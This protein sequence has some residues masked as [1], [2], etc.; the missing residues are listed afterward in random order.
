MIVIFIRFSFTVS[1]P[2][3]Q[4]Y[5]IFHLLKTDYICYIKSS[6]IGSQKGRRQ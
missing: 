6:S 5:H 3:C 2:I 1:P 4:F